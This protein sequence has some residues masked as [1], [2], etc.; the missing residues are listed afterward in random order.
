MT[1]DK[2]TK[3]LIVKDYRQV[4]KSLVYIAEGTVRNLTAYDPE[5]INPTRADLSDLIGEP[6]ELGLNEGLFEYF[7]KI[8]NAL[9]YA[10]QHGHIP[11]EMAPPR[12]PDYVRRLVKHDTRN[13]R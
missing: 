4:Q 3:E 13:T 8:R 6:R 1:L 5:Y 11:E 2:M 12:A 10:L 9:E 7:R